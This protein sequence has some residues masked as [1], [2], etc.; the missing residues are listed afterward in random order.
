MLSAIVGYV[1]GSLPLGFVL[2]RRGGVDLRRV[3]SGNVGAANVYRTAGRGLGVLVM[4]LD[5]GKGAGGVWLRAP[6]CRGRGGRR[7]GRRSWCGRGPIYPLWLRFAGG[8]GVA[9]ACG[10]F[11]VLTPLATVAA[12]GVFAVVTMLTRYVSLG[13]VLATVTLPLVEWARAGRGRS[14]WRPWWR[15]RSFSSATGATWPGWPAAP[16]GGSASAPP[17][18]LTA[19]AV[20]ALET[21]RFMEHVAV[22]GAEAGC[23]PRGAPGPGRAPRCASGDATPGWS[24]TCAGGGPTR[25]TCRT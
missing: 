17:R 22:V 6:C 5:V 11:A 7:R 24:P 20:P 9:V 4:L 15:R 1:V 25:S 12:A 18:I 13:S 3:G 10:V 23:C 19:R 2:A 8:K 14:R 21:T 16:S